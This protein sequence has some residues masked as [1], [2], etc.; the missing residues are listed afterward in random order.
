MPFVARDRGEMLARKW[1]SRRDIAAMSEARMVAM[2]ADAML[3]PADLLLSYAAG[4]GATALD[5][6]ARSHAGRQSRR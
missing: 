1:L 5:R 3:L 4:R 6:L 2:T